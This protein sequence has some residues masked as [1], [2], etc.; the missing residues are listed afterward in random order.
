MIQ[1]LYYLTSKKKSEKMR[2]TN[3][4]SIIQLSMIVST[5]RQPLL[6]VLSFGPIFGNMDAG[7]IR[8]P[9]TEISKAKRLQI[10]DYAYELSNVLRAACA[11]LCVVLDCRLIRVFLVRC[12]SCIAVVYARPQ[13]QPTHLSFHWLAGKLCQ[14]ET[15]YITKMGQISQGQAFIENFFQDNGQH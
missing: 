7:D 2:L 10:H 12:S 11:K 15:W 9:Q 13:P 4:L 14:L 6:P 8:R 1:W 5:L 3:Q